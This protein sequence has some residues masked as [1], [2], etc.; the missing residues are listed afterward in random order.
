M[1]KAITYGIYVFIFP[2]AYAVLMCLSDLYAR[3]RERSTTNPEVLLRETHGGDLSNKYITKP[4]RY[5]SAER[6]YRI[7]ALVAFSF[8]VFYMITAFQCGS[9]CIPLYPAILVAF[10]YLYDQAD[11]PITTAFSSG[12]RSVVRMGV[13]SFG[14]VSLLALSWFPVID[15]MKE[16]YYGY[17]SKLK[18]TLMVFAGTMWLVGNL[19]YAWDIPKRTPTGKAE[20]DFHLSE[21]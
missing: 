21:S 19:L 1:E 18:F 11:K 5:V 3:R 6:Q 20:G 14:L 12:H 13:W 17:D 2:A 16:P 15:A 10:A 8:P 9:F 7:L 4:T